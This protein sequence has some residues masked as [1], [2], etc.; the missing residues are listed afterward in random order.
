MSCPDCVKGAYLPGEPSGKMGFKGA[1]YSAAPKVQTEGDKPGS[2]LNNDSAVVL[3]TDG[4]GLP[5][6]NCKIIA[7][8]LAQRL[9]CDVWVPDIL[10][11]RPLVDLDS[12]LL[13]DRAGVQMTISDWVKFILAAIPKVPAFLH[14]TSSKADARIHG[15][16]TGLRE[17]KKYTKIGAVG[18]CFGGAAS[19]RLA[20]HPELIDCAVICHPG[21]H[22]VKEVE[23]IKVPVSWACAEED[24]FF[25]KKA[26][27]AAEGTLAR[28]DGQPTFVDHQFVDYKGSTTHGF[29]ARPNLEVAE[30]KTAFEGALT[31]AVEW[32]S[33]HL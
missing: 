27:L 1:Y 13:P 10:D 6:K 25:S 21:P 9:G 28:R 7:D 31:Q 29:A 24:L 23:R 12:L 17:D 15:F 19:I 5:L 14:S 32:F 4:Y 16:I 8:T 2:P 33:K 20:S 3:L 30:V 18:Y 26:R 11:G 22:S